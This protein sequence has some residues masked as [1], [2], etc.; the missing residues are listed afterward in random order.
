M[1]ST[2]SI[3]LIISWKSTGVSARWFISVTVATQFFFG[4]GSGAGFLGVAWVVVVTVIEYSFV[5]LFFARMVLVYY[6]VAGGVVVSWTLT[7]AL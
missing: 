3:I 4:E 6:L 7:M 1:S 5:F 2:L